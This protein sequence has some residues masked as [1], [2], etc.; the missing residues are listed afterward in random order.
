[1]P[2]VKGRQQIPSTR[3]VSARRDALRAQEIQGMR[4][5]SAG[6]EEEKLSVKKSASEDLTRRTG[7]V[8]LGGV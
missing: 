7:R 6:G 3:A 5:V 4:T 8:K 2:P 1:M